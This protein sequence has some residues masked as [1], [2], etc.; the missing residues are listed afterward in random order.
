M[1][2]TLETGGCGAV[3]ATQAGGRAGRE[4]LVGLGKE[5]GFYPKMDA[6]RGLWANLPRRGLEGEG[7]A[8]GLTGWYWTVQV[9]GASD[10]SE[11]L[12]VGDLGDGLTLGVV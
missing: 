8:G 7:R 1:F 10:F 6:V 4:G 9:R 5:I 11:R 2:E 12:E 3:V